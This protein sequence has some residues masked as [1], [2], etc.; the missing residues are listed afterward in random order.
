MHVHQ[1]EDHEV[2][3]HPGV[4][5]LVSKSEAVFLLKV[6]QAFAIL[7]PLTIL[8]DIFERHSHFLLQSD[9]DR[10]LER[11]LSLHLLIENSKRD[12]LEI[13]NCGD[14]FIEKNLLRHDIDEVPFLN[15]F[16]ILIVANLVGNSLGEREVRILV[17]SAEITVLVFGQNAIDLSRFE[18]FDG[19]DKLD[20]V[21]DLLFDLLHEL[22]VDFVG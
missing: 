4:L 10:R 2:R 16:K 7:Q 20:W 13:C 12:I 1:L 5:D 19:V 22:T 14:L 21:E 3:N 18:I 11:L 9:A 17:Q 15:I 6:S 8:Y